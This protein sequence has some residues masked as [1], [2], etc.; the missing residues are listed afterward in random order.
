MRTSACLELTA[1]R[2]FQSQI[3]HSLIMS[4]ELTKKFRTSVRST[5]ESW[6]THMQWQHACLLKGYTAANL[7]ANFLILASSSPRHT[8]EKQTNKK[9]H[10]LTKNPRSKQF[11]TPTYLQNSVQ[12]GFCKTGVRLEDFIFLASVL[13][14][15]QLPIGLLQDLKNCCPNGQVKNNCRRQQ[16]PFVDHIVQSKGAGCAHRRGTSQDGKLCGTHLQ[17]IVTLMVL[18]WRDCSVSGSQWRQHRSLH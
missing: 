17:L 9:N 13:L 15:S 5:H 12:V 11:T 18:I 10:K 8:E 3:Q 4:V 16:G 2:S 1:F 14:H 7:W 6:L